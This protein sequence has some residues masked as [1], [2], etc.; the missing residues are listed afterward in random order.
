M[1]RLEETVERLKTSIASVAHLQ[2]SHVLGL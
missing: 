2:R 1:R